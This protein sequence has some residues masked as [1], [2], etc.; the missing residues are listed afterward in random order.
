ML[1]VMFQITINVQ[2]TRSI[3]E[4]IRQRTPEVLTLL[5]EKGSYQSVPELHAAEIGPI[6]SSLLQN[7]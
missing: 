5:A 6:L 3:P 2:A 1:H 7:K 4:N